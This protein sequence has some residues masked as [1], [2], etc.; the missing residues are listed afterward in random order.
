MIQVDAATVG[1]HDLPESESYMAVNSSLYF[2]DGYVTT[3]VVL[4]AN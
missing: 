2:G 3:N 4:K 1:N